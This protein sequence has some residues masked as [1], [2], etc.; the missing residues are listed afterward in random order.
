MI[1]LDEFLSII[2]VDLDTFVADWRCRA[3]TEPDMFPLEQDNFNEWLEDFIIFIEERQAE[4]SP[5]QGEYY[6]E[7][8]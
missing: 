5:L 2:R 8:S 7:F 3:E 1:T 6:N 4:Q